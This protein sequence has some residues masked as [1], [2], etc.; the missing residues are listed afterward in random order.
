M[1]FGFHVVTENFCKLFSVFW[2]VSVLHGYDCIH[3]VAK[4]CTTT[5]YRWLSLDSHPSLRILWSGVI[6][7]PNSSARGNAP[8]ERLGLP[9][10]T[11]ISATCFLVD[12]STYLHILTLAF[13]ITSMHLPFWPRCKLIHIPNSTTI[14]WRDQS[15]LDVM[16]ER[17]MDD[18]W[19]I[20]GNRDMV[21]PAVYPRLSSH[22]F[23]IQ[24]TARKSHCLGY[25]CRLPALVLNHF[26][27]QSRR[28][29]HYE[30]HGF[31]CRSPA[32]VL[33]FSP[34]WHAEHCTGNRIVMDSPAVSS[35]LFSTTLTFRTPQENHIVSVPFETIEKKQKMLFS[36][37]FV[38]S[39]TPWNNSK[40][41]SRVDDNRK[42]AETSEKL[43]KSLSGPLVKLSN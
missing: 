42:I 11:I 26:N 16:L 14:H 10:W 43:A 39:R 7:S 40:L 12:V 24:S 2:K 18:Y 22:H 23:D 29:Y 9:C 31:S 20:E 33:N 32:F 36:I 5:A 38:I 4:S 37:F 8:K 19:N 35:R 6:K 41:N 34:L 1:T 15:T 27:I 3:C 13:S 30:S 17:R 28:G 21:S 25:S